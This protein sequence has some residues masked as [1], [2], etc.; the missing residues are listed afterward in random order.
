MPGAPYTRSPT[1]LGDA[2]PLHDPDELAVPLRHGRAR[3]AQ[4]GDR[5]PRGAGAP[6]ALP[7]PGGRG[8]LRPAAGPRA[9]AGGGGDLRLPPHPGAPRV[10]AGERYGST[11]DMTVSALTG[12]A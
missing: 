9:P 11:S 1:R 12:C 3:A 8:A 5:R 6:A 4:G 10:A 2:L 7:A